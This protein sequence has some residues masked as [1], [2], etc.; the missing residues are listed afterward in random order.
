MIT[1]FPGQYIVPHIIDD[2]QYYF[3]H[4]WNQNNHLCNVNISYIACGLNA[5]SPF[6]SQAHLLLAALLPPRDTK[7]LRCFSPLISSCE[8]NNAPR[9]W[10]WCTD[11]TLFSSKYTHTHSDILRPEKL[12]FILIYRAIN[13]FMII[14]PALFPIKHLNNS[15]GKYFFK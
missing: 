13:W 11:W 1:N 5:G 7:I 6:F 2:K 10:D 9:C 4:N 8:V 14:V 15:F 3:R 12:L